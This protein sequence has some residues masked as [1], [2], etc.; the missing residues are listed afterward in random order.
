MIICFPKYA[1]GLSGP[2]L[3]WGAVVVFKIES[4]MIRGFIN[5]ETGG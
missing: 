2:M 3:A 1:I 5:V 4:P